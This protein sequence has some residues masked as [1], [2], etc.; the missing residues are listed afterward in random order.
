MLSD[1]KLVYFLVIPI[2]CK[3]LPLPPCASSVGGK[4]RKVN[5]YKLKKEKEEDAYVNYVSMH[6][7]FFIGV[8]D[9]YYNSVFLCE[10]V[11]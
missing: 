10:S 6:F 9:R 7:R 5:D 2:S 4:M 1:K 3:V 11:R 8:K